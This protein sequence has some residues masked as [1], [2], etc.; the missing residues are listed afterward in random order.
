MWECLRVRCPGQEAKGGGVAV[1]KGLENWKFIQYQ[2]VCRTVRCYVVKYRRMLR[3][4]DRDVVVKAAVRV[5]RLEEKLV[6]RLVGGPWGEEGS[7][8][9]V[10]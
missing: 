5:V 4:D 7:K 1:R 8:G 3:S 6:G 9:Q 2:C 10:L